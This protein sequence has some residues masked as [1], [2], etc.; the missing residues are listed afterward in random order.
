M[1]ESL[2]SDKNVQT[3]NL[4]P[5]KPVTG[6]IAVQTS[7]QFPSA[8]RQQSAEEKSSIKIMDRDSGSVKQDVFQARIASYPGIC[9]YKAYVEPNGD[10]E[11]KSMA[12]QEWKL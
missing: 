8:N 6:S 12:A 1:E 10:S 5:F 7:Q 3:S 4:P 9:N 11:N 2:R